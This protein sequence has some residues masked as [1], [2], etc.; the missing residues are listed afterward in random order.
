[1]SSPRREGV[2]Q[3]VPHRIRDDL[4][5]VF[6]SR[7]NPHLTSRFCKDELYPNFKMVSEPIDRV[8]HHLYTRVKPNSVGNAAV[9]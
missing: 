2:C 1:M 4:V 9:Y 3:G 8:I 6:I 7:D 5:N